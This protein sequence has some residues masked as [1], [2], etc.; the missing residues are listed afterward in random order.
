[1]SQQEIYQPAFVKRLFNEMAATYGITNYI[2]SFGFCERWR[3][4]CV[5][6]AA[7]Q[8]G[9]VVC[10]L[11]TGMGECWGPIQRRLG[12]EGRLIALDFSQEMCRR[13]REHCGRFSPLP[14]QIY[15][16]NVLAN[17]IPD[18]SVDRVVSSFGLKTFAPEH[19]QALAEEIYRI[20]KPGG[21]FSLLEISV[22]RQ[23]LLRWPYMFYLKH[24][25]P[26]I[27]RLLLGNPD[28]YRLL[29]RYT[30]GFGDSRAMGEQLR[31]AG[32]TVTCRDYFFGC[33]SGVHGVR[34]AAPMLAQA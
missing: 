10:D 25:I 14:I 34:P 8:P 18:A 22:P 27:G 16:E 28:N 26:L 33:A 30:E 17:S 23:A 1:M 29:G 6:Q 12:F 24:A 15:E 5:A 11:M 31:A 3:E 9:M 20:L 32:L 13:G 2:S 19:Q 21:I 4:Q 7:L